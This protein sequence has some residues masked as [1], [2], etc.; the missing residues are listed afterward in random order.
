LALVFCVI[1]SVFAVLFGSKHRSAQQRHDGLV[2]AIAFESLVKFFVLACV[3]GFSL[4]GVFG[5]VQ[6][7][8][9]WLL[10]NPEMLTALR[11]PLHQDAARSLMLLFFSV[12]ICMPQ[13]FHMLFTENPSPQALHTASWGFSIV[14]LLFSLPVLPILWGALELKSP[15]PPE[16]FALGIGIELDRPLLALLVFIGGLSAASG[17]IVVT[18][19][20]MASMTLNHL[21]LPFYQPSTSIDIYRWLLWVRRTL[22]VAMIVGAY[23]IYRSI[24]GQDTLSSLGMAACVAA[25]QFMPGVLAVLYWPRANRIGSLG[26][27]LAGFLVW[28]LALLLPLI[29]DANPSPLLGVLL[30]IPPPDELWSGATIV[31]LGLNKLIFAVLSLLTPTA[32]EERAAAEVCALDE[33]NRPKRLRLKV[34]DAD[35]IEQRLTETLGKSG[36]E[37]EVRRALADL[38]LDRS[39]NRPYALRRL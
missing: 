8:D 14:L 7:L 22:I 10:A 33:L 21:I 12:T 4:F 20:A 5:G 1:I 2:V 36:A 19:L 3:A 29:S 17:T 13:M 16:Y 23:W 25:L 15:L 11:S 32:P 28:F 26:G 30:G 24:G 39:E 18:T 34:R 9:N 31:S 6:G 38:K 27:L 35:E 37:R